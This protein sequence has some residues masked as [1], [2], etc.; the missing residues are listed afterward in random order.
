MN[1]QT[2]RAWI[3]K[4]ESDWK[5]GRDEMATE[6]PATDTICFHMQ[7]CAEKFLK[8]FLIFNGREIRKTHDL[9]EII[10]EC[11]E[12]DPDFQKLIE[13]KVQNLT[14]FGVQFRYPMEIMFPSREETEEAIELTQKVK[15]FVAAK[16]RSKGY[17]G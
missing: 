14:E 4:A 3:S 15:Y 8:A 11:K 10:T 7:Q 12:L 16:L 1:E 13:L 5:T 17:K 2:V 9:A 6:N